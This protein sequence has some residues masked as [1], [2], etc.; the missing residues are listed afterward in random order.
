MS[1]TTL[2]RLACGIAAAALTAS[3]SADFVGLSTT[4]LPTDSYMEGAGIWT[5]DVFA[6]F[7]DPNDRLIAVEGWIQ[8]DV[9]MVYHHGIGDNTAPDSQFFALFPLLQY[10]SFVTIGLASTD[11]GTTDDTEFCPGFQSWP[12][13]NSNAFWGCWFNA[14]DNPQGDADLY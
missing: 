13:N 11:N 12:F 4:K 7:D 9:S 3:A 5:I 2:S 6:V 8:T 10:D 1:T 14:T